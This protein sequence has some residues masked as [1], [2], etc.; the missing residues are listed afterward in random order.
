MVI[1]KQ[2]QI[3]KILDWFNFERVHKTMTFLDWKWFSVTSFE[4]PGIPE[5]REKARE[6]LNEAKV[7]SIC[8]GGFRVTLYPSGE[9]SLAF[10]LD[11]SDG[12]DYFAPGT[13]FEI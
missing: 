3:T 12:S 11:C 6:M 7:G 10:E 2:E 8:T 13:E 5:L 4:V 9:L 1:T